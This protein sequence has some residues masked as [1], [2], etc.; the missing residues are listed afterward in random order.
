MPI[1]DG[2]GGNLHDTFGNFGT[3]GGNPATSG[4]SF[5]GWSSGGGSGGYT[6]NWGGASNGMG[7]VP[8]PQYGPPAPYPGG[9]PTPY[10]QTPVPPPVTG[11]PNPV[12][13]P[14]SLAA[15]NDALSRYA[16]AAASAFAQTQPPPTDLTQAA[17]DSYNYDPL[18]SVSP[19]AADPYS[20]QTVNPLGKTDMFTQIDRPPEPTLGVPGT[21]Q[22]TPMG[23]PSGP[24]GMSFNGPPATTQQQP[25]I[26]N[27]DYLRTTPGPAGMSFTGGGLPQ[28][29]LPGSSWAQPAGS[30]FD[31]PSYDQQQVTTEPK[32]DLPTMPGMNGI[33]DYQNLAEANQFMAGPMGQM[34][35]VDP[36]NQVASL[37]GVAPYNPYTSPFYAGD[38]FSNLADYTSPFGK[39]FADRVPSGNY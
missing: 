18:S 5:A 32:T 39:L 20:Q 9:I 30:A 36:S 3:F 17:Y 1:N 29:A 22:N 2:T 38:A 10:T 14:S 8:T 16:Q 7:G 11:Y 19:P 13:D 34:Y 23:A 24:S 12:A 25:A 35:G 27:Y 15:V 4:G 6:G 33:T 37:M 26:S 31:Q 21:A 28:G